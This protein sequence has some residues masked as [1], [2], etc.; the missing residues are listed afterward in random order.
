ML[1]LVFNDSEKGSVVW[2]VDG[3]MSAKGIGRDHSR[4]KID[5]ALTLHGDAARLLT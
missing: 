4:S 2:L 1:R 3:L 5:K